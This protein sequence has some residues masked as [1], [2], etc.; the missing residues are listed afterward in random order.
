[1]SKSLDVTSE[2]LPTFCKI[3]QSN[4]PDFPIPT[5]GHKFCEP[6]IKSYLSLKITEAQVL[7][8]TCPESNCPQRIASSLISDL[9]PDLFEKYL[10]FTQNRQKE[11]DPN[12][13]WCPKLSCSGFDIK[14]TSNNLKCKNCQF[15]FCYVCNEAWHEGFCKDLII[16]INKNI[17]RCP[18]C[19]VYVEKKSGCP[20]MLCSN[21]SF[22]FCWL[23]DQGLS[24]HS[25]KKCFLKSNRSRFYWVVGFTLLLF[26]LVLLFWFPFMLFLFTYVENGHNEYLMHKKKFIYGFVVGGVLSPL[27]LP[28]VLFLLLSYLAFIVVRG[29]YYKYSGKKLSKIYFFTI[30]TP[31]LFCLSFLGSL[32]ILGVLLPLFPLSGVFILILRVTLLFSNYSQL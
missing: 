3:C 30:Y 8:I 27:I 31:A 9:L 6:C 20:E 12:F 17:K 7:F 2:L 23:C 1:M 21:C 19:S 18:N 5:C 14:L 32:V 26:P 10:K 22:G 29:Q 13:R 15:E 24:D 25:I 28:L 16:Q 4:T 11:S